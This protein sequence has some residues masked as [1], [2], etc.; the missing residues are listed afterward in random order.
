MTSDE[1]LALLGVIENDRLA[2]ST[3]QNAIRALSGAKS[4][5]GD[6]QSKYLDDLST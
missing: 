1:Q 6:V 2:V 3:R 4:L 5:P